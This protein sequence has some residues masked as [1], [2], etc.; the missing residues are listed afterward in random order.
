M[1]GTFIIKVKHITYT[2][3]T[4]YLCNKIHLLNIDVIIYA[5]RCCEKTFYLKINVLKAIN[6]FSWIKVSR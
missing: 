4:F 5:Y 3:I 1:F 2:G 6:I